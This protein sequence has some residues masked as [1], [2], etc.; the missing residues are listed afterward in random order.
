MGSSRMK[1]WSVVGA[2][3]ELRRDLEPLG[4]AARQLGRGLAQAQVAE[5]DF[6]QHLEPPLQHRLGGEE[7][8]RLVH[9]LLQHLADV[10]AL[11]GDLEHVGAIAAALALLAGHVHVLDEVHLELLE[12]VALARLAATA[13]HVEREGAG[14]EAERLGSRQ[15]REEPPD[16]VEG[17][18]VR[19]RIGAG[20]A[21]DRLLVDEP[22][23][24]EMLQTPQLVV[25]PRDREV[26]LEVPGHRPVERVVHE[27]GFPGAGDPGHAGQ[28]V[29]RDPH[30][31]VL[32]VVRA[33]ARE[34]EGAPALPA[35]ERQ[36]DG[37][38]AAQVARGQRAR[39]LA[40]LRLGAREDHGAAALARAR[41]PSRSRSRP[42]RSARDRARRSPPCCRPRRARGRARPAARCPARAAR[43]TARRARRACR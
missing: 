9:R 38:A 28:S 42:P 20:R 3:G 22:D 33:R 19:D 41:A 26:H 27:R 10:P 12:A 18:H 24:L 15:A 7:V 6:L 11:V 14:T 8:D 37:V 39:I 29:Q 21:P 34:D 13:R 4:L 32:Q 36:G 31:D 16:L 35:R 17:L 25:G 2:R 5:P 23:A 40:E 43:W 30:R 1:R